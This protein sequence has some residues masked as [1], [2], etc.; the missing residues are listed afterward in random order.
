MSFYHMLEA[1][2]AIDW[3][4]IGQKVIVGIATAV[5]LGGLTL[6]W[7]WGSNGG[8]VRALGGITEKDVKELVRQGT[9]GPAI[10]LPVNTIIAFDDPGTCSKLGSGWED[11]NLMGKILIGASRGDAR[12]DY[13]KSGG[14][15]SITIKAANMPP[16][17]L[18]YHTQLSGPGVTISMVDKLT[19]EQPDHPPF[20]QTSNQPAAPIDTMPPYVPIYFCKRTT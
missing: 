7:N 4:G 1:I 16:L 5:V 18:A 12:W 13:R 6:L 17:Y 9:P 11:A 14:D 15:T 19:F 3:D 10:N 8:I 2:M 20:L